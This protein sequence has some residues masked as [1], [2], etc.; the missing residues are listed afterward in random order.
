MTLC[1]CCGNGCGLSAAD[2]QKQRRDRTPQGFPQGRAVE[3]RKPR[4]YRFG[5]EVMCQRPQWLQR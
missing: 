3:I 5:F 2:A 4:N 1:L